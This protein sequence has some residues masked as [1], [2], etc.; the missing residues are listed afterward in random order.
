MNTILVLRLALVGAA[1]ATEPAEPATPGAKAARAEE[2]AN[3]QSKDAAQRNHFKSILDSKIDLKF[4]KASL[5]DVLAA[6][7][8]KTGV[9]FVLDT[10][11]F[12][13]ESVEL[14]ELPVT[15]DVA[16]ITVASALNIILRDQALR[17]VRCNEAVFVTTIAGAETMFELRVY[18]VGDLVVRENER[19][20]HSSYVPKTLVADGGGGGWGG[21]ITDVDELIGTITSTVAPTTWGEVGGAGA[22]KFLPNALAL[23]IY[24]TS[25]AL[26]DVE[27]LL[28]MLREARKS[29]LGA[30]TAANR[31][32]LLLATYAMPRHAPTWHAVWPGSATADANAQRYEAELKTSLANAAATAK[33]FAVV[34]PQVIEPASWKTA[35]GKGEIFVVNDRLVI[36]QTAAVHA[37]VARLLKDNSPPTPG[38]PL[39]HGTMD[40]R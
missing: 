34:I 18:P 6:I 25:E 5:L 20:P 8:A 30:F 14:R 33:E 17:W 38:H 32:D 4:D 12:A 7:R 26:D 28:S 2:S 23:T 13:V 39:M 9:N 29:Q 11:Q 36:R 31:N 35:G 40:G 22:I 15:I 37:Q 3:V 10:K 1:L 19:W 24:Q 21:P 16:G 27:V